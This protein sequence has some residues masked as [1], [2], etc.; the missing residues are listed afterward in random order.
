MSLGPIISTT[1]GYALNYFGAG[2]LSC[3]DLELTLETEYPFEPNVQITM[4]KVAVG[5]LALWVRIPAWSKKT[6]VSINSQPQSEA[7]VPGKY[8]KLTRRW[9]LGDKIAVTFDF[10]LRGWTDTTDAF[11]GRV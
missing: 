10:R 11:L 8:L 2:T 7:I 9:V 6:A 1:P 3:A 4:S 5:P